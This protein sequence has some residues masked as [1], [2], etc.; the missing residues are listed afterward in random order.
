MSNVAIDE[1]L[2]SRQMA[3]Y[4]RESMQKLR[5]ASVLVSGLNGLGAEVAK[6]V[7]LANVKK[8]TLHDDRRAS[9]ADCGANF[10]LTEVHAGSNRAAACAK[11]MQEL[12]PEV[13]VRAVDG[14]FGSLRLNDYTVVVAVD[15]PLDAAVRANAYCRAQ[16][17][18]IAF[19]RADVRGLAGFAFVD[20]GPK[21]T[22]VDPT[23][24]AIKSAIIENITTAGGGGT[25]V[26]L[27]VQCVE[28]DDLELDDGDHIIFSEVEGMPNLNGMAPLPVSEVS[29]GKKRF[30]VSVP[31][32]HAS[33]A[34][35]R[36]GLVTER[37]MPKQIAH[38]SY[39]SFLTQDP[40]ELWEVD[41]S[42]MAPAAR[43]YSEDFLR[44]FGTPQ[45]NAMYGRSGLLRI[46]FR[47]LDAYQARHGRLPPP[48]DAAAAAEVVSLAEQLNAGSTGVRVCELEHPERAKVVR[49]LAMGSCAVL[50]PMCAIFGGIVGQEVVKAS[51]GKFHP[52]SQG[53][54]LD[55]FEALPNKELPLD[56][57]FGN[58]AAAG[59]YAGQ[60]A[61]FGRS[62]QE[63]LSSLRIF[64]VGS[65]ALGCEF[66]KNFALMGVCTAAASH[67]GALL[68]VTDDDIIEKSNLS[69]QFLFR[70]HDVGTSKSVAAVRAA[71]AMNP[72]LR[73]S[74]LQDRV[75]P[76]TE[77]VFNSSFWLSLDVVV[78]AL[79]NVMARLYVDQQCVFYSK[80]LLES[81]TL[82]TKCNTQMVLPHLTENYGASRDA[83]EKQAP[84]CAVH[85]FPHNIDQCLVL[86]QSEFNGAFDT[87]PSDLVSFLSEGAGWV[88]GLAASQETP[89]SILDKLRGDP[90]VLCGVAGGCRDLLIAEPCSSWA[91]C[92]G[93][94]RRRFEAYFVSRVKQLLHNF[95]PDATTS[96]GVPFWSPPKRVP[97][98]LPF[99]PSD[100]LHMQ[101]IIS[102]AHLR[103]FTFG[104][105]PP[106]E[107]RDPRAVAET[108]L[109]SPDCRVLPFQPFL[110]ATIETDEAGSPA[111]AAASGGSEPAA[112]QQEVQSLLAAR[113][114]LP[115][116]FTVHPNPFEKDDGTNFHI[117]FISS[118]GN[119]RAR[120]YGIAGIDPFQAKLKVGRIIPAIATTT[121]MA[122]GFVCLEL[123]KHLTRSPSSISGRRNLFANLALPGPMIMLSEPAPCEKVKS[124]QRWDPDMFMT[125]DEVAVPEGHTI[126]DKI[127]VPNARAMSLE[128][129]FSFFG[130]K[131]SLRVTELLVKGRAIYSESLKFSRNDANRSRRL[132]DLIEELDPGQTRRPF[133]RLEQIVFQTAEGDDVKAATVVLQLA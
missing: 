108:L 104:I 44:V 5:H 68:T 129:L 77:P 4:G 121:A 18:P 8:V 116:A 106:P 125:V 75:A 89:S 2:Q 41:E 72:Q 26:L 118:F 31:R 114:Q 21:F 7:I 58:P 105:R 117:A 33:G 82:G 53:F 14:P 62:V 101:F 87:A 64:L 124:G 85:N 69:R 13:T 99:D 83:P 32:A 109:R 65:G 1:D 112:I 70:N 127:L 54:F 123:Y 95:P 66:L 36:G 67:H 59:R 103:A 34:Y 61:V 3:V 6:N 45:A 113:S 88:D 48:A 47:A 97:T 122:T 115:P 107:G 12:N 43:S 15:V 110:D 27:T 102:A 28:D 92:L 128:N 38:R 131:V 90:R 119:L 55:A 80:P 24:E 11:Q 74:A 19:I 29:K 25:T 51:T 9:V 63:K 10:F 78:N 30:S 132:V 40:G 22:C 50:S 96:Q 86:A 56:A 17:P 42:K 16:K 73:A 57:E 91:Q 84:Q 71:S 133:Y 49:Q 76:E 39:E 126:W 37:R 20:F 93:W 130:A 23:G 81:G 94:A 35:R 52:C 120:N 60:V 100:P 111:A 98:P 79:D 46:A